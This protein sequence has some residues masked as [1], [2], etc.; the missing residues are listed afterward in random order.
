M[1][2]MHFAHIILQAAFWVYIGLQIGLFF[3]SKS[4][5]TPHDPSACTVSLFYS[6]GYL[7]N[8]LLF[9]WNSCDSLLLHS[10]V[11]PES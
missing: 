5:L 6:L 3:T 2:G 9:T 7:H 1:H 8:C 10:Q 11:S 4:L